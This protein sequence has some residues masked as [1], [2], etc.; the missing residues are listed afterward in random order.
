MKLVT[1]IAALLLVPAAAL[2]DPLRQP[3]GC[4]IGYQWQGK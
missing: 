3:G 2:A 1:I 4:P